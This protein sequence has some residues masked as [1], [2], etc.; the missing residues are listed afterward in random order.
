MAIVA[1]A[2][3]QQINYQGYLTD[4][5]ENPL[6]TSVNITFRL[7]G[8]CQPSAPV[9]WTETHNGVAVNQ[10]LFQ[11]TLGATLPLTDAILNQ[12]ELCL[13]VTVGSD[14]EMVPRARVVASG[15]ALRALHSGHVDSISATNM[16]Q[17]LLWLNQSSDADQD[18]HMKIA[19]GGDDCDDWNPA[20]HPGAPEVCD[21]LDNDCD[22][23]VDEGFS[24]HWYRDQDGDGYGDPNQGITACTPQPG[25]VTDSTDCDD[26]NP[27]VFPLHMEVCDGFDN[28]C[29][30][31]TDPPGSPG[32]TT[33]W[34]DNDCDG[35]GNMFTYPPCICGDPGP[36]PNCWATQGGDCDDGLDS[37]HPGAPERC[38]CIDDDCDGSVDEEASC[39]PGQ[40]CQ[41]CNCVPD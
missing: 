26:T 32:C 25:Y 21:G 7:Y 30:G 23:L 28:N 31:V 29:D 39:P 3:P 8:S 19:A 13:G 14:S 38:N 22:G 41:D 40:H 4:A 2:V 20:V 10:G 35:Y 36:G 17:I 11:V 24:V 12:E 27:Q 34:E 5:G 18:G 37:I 16:S 15:Y 9:L 33:Y 1:L 6:T